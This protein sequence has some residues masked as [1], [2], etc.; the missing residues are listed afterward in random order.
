MAI[1]TS[2]GYARTLGIA[3]GNYDQGTDTYTKD[4]PLAEAAKAGAAAVHSSD[5]SKWRLPQANKIVLVLDADLIASN[6]FDG[7]ITLSDIDGTA[8]AEDAV[9]VVYAT[10]HTA[11]MTAIKNAFDA[12]T[13]VS[14][15]LTDATNNREITLTISGDSSVAISTAF[16]VTLGA[17]QAGVTASLESGDVIACILGHEDL[18]G[19]ISGDV[20]QYVKGD[21]VAGHRRGRI[22]VEP[23]TALAVGDSVFARFV[24]G[25]AGEERGSLRNAAA[26]VAT[27]FAGAVVERASSADEI[28]IV[29]IDLVN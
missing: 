12:F 1:Q 21:V 16:A 18:E 14:A 27:A 28:G 22:F 25:V 19:N 26:S 3:G 20:V 9:S 23:D 7:G 5:R 10:S 29:E 2:Y 15:E 24:A 4:L 8:S 6:S 13:N 17:S 11:T